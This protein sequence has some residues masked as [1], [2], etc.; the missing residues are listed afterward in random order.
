MYRYCLLLLPFLLFSCQSEPTA[1]SEATSSESGPPNIVL[2]LTDDQGWGDLGMHG[3][4]FLQ[5]PNI[6]QIATEGAQF[7]RFYVSPVCAPTRA[8]ILTGR[9][10][11]RTG[12]SW[13]THRKE[14]MRSEEKTIAEYLRKANYKTGLFGKWHNGSQY[15]ND[16][17][18]QGFEEFFG[19]T[20][21][22]TNNYF[23]TRV[24]HNDRYEMTK[25][26][27]PD[28]L[29]DA[30]IDFIDQQKEQP[31][32]CFLSLNT[33]HSP[34]QVPDSYFN[35][36]K[37]FGLEDK[38]AAIYGMVENIDDNVGRL[39]NAL[40]SLG[41]KDN[42]L[43]IFLSDNGPNGVRHNGGMKGIKAQVDEGGVR[44]PCLMSWPGKIPAGTIVKELGA[45]IDLLP[46]ILAMTGL[47]P[48]EGIVLDG[49]NLW[50]LLQGKEIEWNDRP[51]FA[52]QNDGKSQSYPSSIRTKQYRMVWDWANVP[53]LYDMISD[54]KQEANIINQ[55]PRVADS[56]AQI[57]QAW[58]QDVTKNGISIPPI[59]VGYKESPRTIC[60][61]PE[62]ILKGNA[63]FKGQKGWA[64]D[65]IIDWS[66]KGGIV[67]WNVDIVEE[68]EYRFSIVHAAK[69]EALD[70]DLF[71]LTA[72]GGLQAKLTKVA[73]SPNVK[74]PDRV[75]RG[76]VYE[77]R[78]IDQSLGV[79]KLAKGPQQIRF[80]TKM[81]D[82]DVFELKAIKID[83][84]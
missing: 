68:G 46:T 65:Y 48:E 23:D 80:Q 20:E 14:V 53:S 36:Y 64:N 51:I 39:S 16:P 42:T 35:E 74:S 34:F 63:A 73:W 59:P 25:G 7:D 5:T 66:E 50:P 17:K 10:A 24:K 70:K 22:H 45:H 67:N 12:T 28:V 54:P 38:E 29:T 8:A 30:A 6:E 57:H 79:I 26:Y 75:K 11:L 78:W 84:L 1:E 32:F 40:D 83:K 4:V 9:Y 2:I 71:L 49:K 82:P 72:Q 27:L 33:P 58:Y 60:Y 47:Q 37:K 52:I 41:L 21:G 44:V 43:I 15:P 62:A 13:V 56:L 3:N 19:F 81:D 18:G 69:E 55:K 76:E 77:R 61:A 31:F